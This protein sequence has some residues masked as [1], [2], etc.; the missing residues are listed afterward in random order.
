MV[1]CPNKQRSS[2]GYYTVLWPSILYWSNKKCRVV[3]QST[4]LEY[5]DL[6]YALLRQ[7]SFNNFFMNLMFSLFQ[8]PYLWWTT[9]MLHILHWVSS[10]GTK[11]IEIDFIFVKVVAE[12]SLDIQYI[13]TKWSNCQ[14]YDQ[15]LSSWYFSIIWGRFSVLN[16]HF[17]CEAFLRGTDVSPY[18][19]S[20][21]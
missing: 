11:S 2:S 6:A 21:I 19:D 12:K 20:L 10:C 7:H 1:R 8:P 16:Y 15:G 18:N 17:A 9:S 14:H 13:S 5:R 3:S 4:K